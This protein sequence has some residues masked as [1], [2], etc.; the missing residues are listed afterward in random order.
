METRLSELLEY[1]NRH[2]VKIDFRTAPLADKSSL[3]TRATDAAMAADER[4]VKVQAVLLNVNQEVQISTRTASR[5]RP[6]PTGTGAQ[7][8]RWS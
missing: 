1:E 7:N 8:S 5:G 3:L 4:I 2:P 6:G